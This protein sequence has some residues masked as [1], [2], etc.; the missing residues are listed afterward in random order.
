M[1]QAHLLA[2]VASVSVQNGDPVAVLAYIRLYYLVRVLRSYL[3]RHPF[4]AMV[5]A[6]D[7]FRGNK[8]E[9]NGISSIFP[10][11]QV[12]EYTE[13]SCIKGKYILPDGLPQ[14]V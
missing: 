10:A 6:V 14:P 2:A 12:A 13:H 8:L 11:E 9:H 7:G 3:E 1:Q 5:K 4:V